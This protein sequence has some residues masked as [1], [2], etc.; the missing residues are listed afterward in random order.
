VIKFFKRSTWVILFFLLA[1][2]FG[3][4]ALTTV[5]KYDEILRHA[6]MEHATRGQQIEELEDQIHVLKEQNLKKQYQIDQLTKRLDQAEH[7][8]R[9]LDYSTVKKSKKQKK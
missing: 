5:I 1:A 2:L 4:V 7:E 8:I 6:Q 3:Y 9:V